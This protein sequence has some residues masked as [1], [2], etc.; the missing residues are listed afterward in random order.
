ACDCLVWKDPVNVLGWPRLFRLLPKGAR[1]D[2]Y[3]AQVKR[4]T[5]L[6]F[7]SWGGF[8][9]NFADRRIPFEHPSYSAYWDRA[10][11]ESLNIP[12]FAAGASGPYLPGSAIQ[13][14]LRTG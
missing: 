11:G 9:Q 14:A 10:A 2:G 13:G 1:L 6:D 12:T 5:K 4:A 7:A 8:A 3:L